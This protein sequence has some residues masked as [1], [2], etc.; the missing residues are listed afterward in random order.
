[1]NNE[2]FAYL[3]KNQINECQKVLGNKA[4]EYATNADR[5]DNF[6]TAAALQHLTVRQALA[7]MM[8]KHTVS[9]YDMC[10]SDESYSLELWA[11]KIGD[12]LNY[13]FL[14]NA[15]IHEEAL[16]ATLQGVLEIPDLKEA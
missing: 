12:H 15:V 14:L 9:I 7:G 5:L 10:R 13:L 3:L 16:A 4:Y 8:A 6:K 2:E 11:E 1:M